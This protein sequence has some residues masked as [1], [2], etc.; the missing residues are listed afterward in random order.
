VDKQQLI[1]CNELWRRGIIIS[2]IT[3]IMVNLF[4]T[5]FKRDNSVLGVDIGSSSIKVV[6]IK[7]QKGKVFLENYGSLALGPYVELAVGRAT[8][9][10]KEKIVEALMDLLRE[11]GITAK[12]ASIAIPMRDTMISLIKMPNLGKKQLEEMVPIEARKHIPVP[13]SEV[14]LNFWVIPQEKEKKTAAGNSSAPAVNEVLIA[15]IHNDS[16]NKYQEIK[17]HAGFNAKMF[18]V[19]I[20]ST[21]RSVVGNDISLS[22]VVDIG[23]GTTKLTMVEYGIVKGSHVISR[24]SQD[25]TISLSKSLKV[26]IDRAEEIKRDPVSA[27]EVSKNNFSSVVSLPIGHIFSEAN[28]VLLDYQKK[29]NKTVKKVFLSGG[30]ALLDGLPQLAKENFKTE[31]IIGDPFGR[32]ETPAFLNETLKKAGPEFAVAIGAALGAL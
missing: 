11:A 25:V 19:E 31:I 18:E 24:G 5:I 28:S 22:M 26:S 8:N 2:N 15:A 17:N 21:I 10:T 1:Y 16:I 32:L 12:N 27:K 9:M 3:Y 29:H 20:F 13:M 6:Q 7:Q 14:T 30:G 23:A 4:E